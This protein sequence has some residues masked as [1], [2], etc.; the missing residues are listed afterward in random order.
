MPTNATNSG[1]GCTV[2]LADIVVFF[3]LLAH[4]PTQGRWPCS[5][6]ILIVSPAWCLHGVNMTDHGFVEIVNAVPQVTGC[7]LGR[8]PT[9]KTSSPSLTW[10][11]YRHNIC[12]DDRPDH[13]AL[14][15]CR[16]A[17]WGR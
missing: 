14:P 7:Y 12:A 10:A 5:R 11:C 8:A 1:S 17:R 6:E 15:H 4:Q 13:L 2:P 3:I 9:W 16:K